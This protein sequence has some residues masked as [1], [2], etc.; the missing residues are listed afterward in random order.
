MLIQCSFNHWALKTRIK[1]IYKISVGKKTHYDFNE[2]RGL[3]S[4]WYSTRQQ[5]LMKKVESTHLKSS[6]L[7]NCIFFFYSIFLEQF[8]PEK[9]AGRWC[10]LTAMVVRKMV[11]F[12]LSIHAHPQHPPAQRGQAGTKREVP[13]A[14]RANSSFPQQQANVDWQL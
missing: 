12:R 1:A 10:L 11:K 14:P 4:N 2:I 6:L 8:P 9:L 7:C 5:Q 13:T 3:I